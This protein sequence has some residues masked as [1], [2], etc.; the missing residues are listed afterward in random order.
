MA[1]CNRVR[2]G[3]S[4]FNK[5]TLI[6]SHRSDL[7]RSLVVPS[8]SLASRNYANV[9]G[10]RDSKV[11]VPLALFGGSGNYASA[12]YI[13]SVKAN[14]IEK[15]ESEILQFVEAVK[16][17]S[18]FSQFV[19]DVSVAKAIRVK[20]IQEVCGEAKFSDL[21]KNFLVIVAENGR[22]KN[23]ETIAKRFT[24]LAMAYKGEVKATVTTVVALPP[25]EEKALKETLQEIIGS[26]AKVHLEQKIDPSILG[27]LVLEFSQKVFDMS[28]KTRAQQME[29]ILREPVSIA[30]I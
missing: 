3:I 13:A 11:K 12:L 1:L 24:E 8:V 19:K 7:H 22:L 20:V 5:S 27:G 17:S 16:N 15:V 26:G 21:T 14:A 18:K 25:E 30:N 2:S 4:L 29:R 6:T 9:P 10:A 23:L 28:I